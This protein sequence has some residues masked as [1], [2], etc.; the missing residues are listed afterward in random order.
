[1]G[2]E[3][4]PEYTSCPHFQRGPDKCCGRGHEE[5]LN[6]IRNRILSLE[7]RDGTVL[8][9]QANVL[10]ETY[11]EYD[12]RWVTISPENPEII[13]LYNSRAFT[14]DTEKVV[15]Q[16]HHSDRVLTTMLE[17]CPFRIVRK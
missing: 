14:R 10:G 2:K 6:A 3:T 7:L 15:Y 4:E 1:M 12:E 8:H 13:N 5:K 11:N 9:M 17:G 16:H